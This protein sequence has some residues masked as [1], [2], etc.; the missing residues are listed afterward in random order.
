V[1]LKF[2]SWG[3]REKNLVKASLL[4]ASFSSIDCSFSSSNRCFFC[5]TEF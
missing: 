1:I 2:L 4:K 3:N 5:L